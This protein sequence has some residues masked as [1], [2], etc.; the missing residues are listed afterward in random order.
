MAYVPRVVYIDMPKNGTSKILRIWIQDS[1]DNSG[2]TGIAYTNV[3]IS[4]I[5]SDQ[6]DALLLTPSGEATTVGTWESNKWKEVDST[7]FAGLY[8]YGMPDDLLAGG[9]QTWVKV[10]DYGIVYC[11]N[12]VNVDFTD[13]VRMGLTCLPNVDFGNDGG[14]IGAGTGT[15][16]L[17]ASSGALNGSVASVTGA[18]GSVT[19]N[20]GGTIGSLAAQAKTDVKGEVINGLNAE[21]PAAPTADSAYAELDH[22]DADIT[23]R[24]ATV[25]LTIPTA[26]DIRAEIDN[27]STDLD[28]IIAKTN[29]LGSGIVVTCSPMRT[30]EQI[31]IIQGND[32][33]STDSMALSWSSTAWTSLLG[34]T[35]KFIIKGVAEYTA[36]AT[37]TTTQTVTCNLTAAQTAAI[38]IAEY[39]YD[40]EATL[41]S[42]RIISLGTGKINVVEKISA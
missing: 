18:V 3:T 15:R 32:Y 8:E 4:Y 14:L 36:T 23:S 1:S 5:R 33:N 2:F 19:G 31:E 9:S 29:M 26:A 12:L 28:A 6:N 41:S 17:N 10:N 11:I 40:L 25:S 39:E 21:S 20:V 27:N 22:L 42:G 30:A 35:V 38:N 7:H 13:P 37:G 34:A 24:A 16:Q